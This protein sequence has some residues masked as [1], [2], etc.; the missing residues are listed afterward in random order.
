[1]RQEEGEEEGE[2]LKEPAPIESSS[3]SVPPR[4]SWKIRAL[5]SSCPAG[6]LEI[7]IDH[8]IRRTRGVTIG[9]EWRN[10]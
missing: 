4:G 2:S 7:E 5:A 3:M 9:V 1:M 8:M 10:R 6:D